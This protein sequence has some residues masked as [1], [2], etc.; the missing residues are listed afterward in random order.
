M[1]LVSGVACKFWQ[2]LGVEREAEWWGSYNLQKGRGIQEPNFNTEKP[3]PKK[4]A[5]DLEMN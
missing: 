3:L 5:A 4:L 1:E 2:G